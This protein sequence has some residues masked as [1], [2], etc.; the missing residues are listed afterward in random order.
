MATPTRNEAI[1]HQVYIERY[2]SQ[3]ANDFI[4]FLKRV[5]KALTAELAEVDL[6]EVSRTRLEK[7]LIGIRRQLSDIYFEW[8]D[9]LKGELADFAEYEAGH[10]IKMM[11]EAMAEPIDFVMPSDKMLAAAVTT[12][13][14]SVR[15]VDGGKLLD[16]FIKDFQEKDIQRLANIIRQGYFEGKTNS[17]IVKQLKTQDLIATE[18][19]A[20]AVTRTAVQHVASQ[21]QQAVYQANDDIVEMVEWVSALDSRTSDLCKGLDGR[22]FPLDSGPRPPAHIGCRS[23]A[24]PVLSDK[25]SYLSDGRTRAARDPETGKTVSVDGGESYYSWLKKQDKAFVDDVIGPTRSKLLREGGLS[26]DEFS[27]LSLGTNFKPMTLDQ[28]RNKNPLAFSKAGLQTQ[29]S[30]G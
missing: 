9:Y 30:P 3:V 10:S 2:K 20:R 14:L 15:G 11:S 24:I 28:M 22:K 4:P 29:K 23:A 16:A 25:Y 5:Q 18:R 17:Q 6:T 27:R 21:A 7:Q 13:P 26:G 8:G 19:N 1:K 12:N